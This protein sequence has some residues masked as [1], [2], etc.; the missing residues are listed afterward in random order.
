[1]ALIAMPMHSSGCCEPRLRSPAQPGL[2]FWGGPA[3]V[4]RQ[5]TAVPFSDWTNNPREITI[6]H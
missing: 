5:R 6:G 1:M 4:S 3:G 2:E